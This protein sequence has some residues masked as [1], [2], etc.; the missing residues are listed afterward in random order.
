MHNS[1]KVQ[2][3]NMY[4]FVLFLFGMLATGNMI[5]VN[6]WRQSCDTVSHTHNPLCYIIML[7]QKEEYVKF[8]MAYNFASKEKMCNEKLSLKIKRIHC[9]EIILTSPKSTFFVISQTEPAER[10][11]HDMLDY[12]PGER[13]SSIETITVNL[14]LKYFG[15]FSVGTFIFPCVLLLMHFLHCSYRWKSIEESNGTASPGSCLWL[16]TSH[17]N[18]SS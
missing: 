11:A 18:V 16:P 12:I 9:Y 1:L 10:R 8:I 5:P 3:F 2:Q 6:D 4:K 14:N 15:L 7:I 17:H 13:E